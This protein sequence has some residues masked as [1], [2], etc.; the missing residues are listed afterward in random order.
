MNSV[1]D[2]VVLFENGT[3]IEGIFQTED[4]KKVVDDLVADVILKRKNLVFKSS[5][6][7]ERKIV[8]ENAVKI[9]KIR[10]ICQHCRECYVVYEL[11]S[12]DDAGFRGITC[13][14][15]KKISYLPRIFSVQ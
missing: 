8:P 13:P 4:I 12:L 14:A 9:N 10:I 3:R 1:Y 7:K 2:V 15:C 11:G 5:F 6:F